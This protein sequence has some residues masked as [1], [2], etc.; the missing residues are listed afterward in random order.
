MGQAAEPGRVSL[1]FELER[2][3]EA[4]G[5]LKLVERQ[6]AQDV[7]RDDGEARA[8]EAGIVEPAAGDGEGGEAEV[9]FGLAAAGREEQ[10]VDDRSVGV[11]RLG[12]AVEVEQDEGERKQPPCRALCWSGGFPFRVEPRWRLEHAMT[13][14][15]MA[16]ASRLATSVFSLAI[17]A[18]IRFRAV[19]TSFRH[20]FA[21]S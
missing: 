7:A 16:K 3:D 18:S 21:T 2:A 11:R 14:F 20:F 19:S 8:F 17:P 10:Q 12:E 5:A 4:R 1:P 15:M 6:K 13:R 9:G